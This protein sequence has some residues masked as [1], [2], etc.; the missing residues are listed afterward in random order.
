MYPIFLSI[1][2]KPCV[3]VGGGYVAY[4]K[5]HNLIDEGAVVTVVAEESVKEIVDMAEKGL[6]TLK[7]KR[8]EPSDVENAYLVF[9]A[10]NDKDVN[11]DVTTAAK[12]NKAL[13]NTVDT[14]DLCEFYSG[15]VVN[16]GPL[17]IAISTGGCSPGIAGQIRRELEELYPEPYEEFIETAGEMRKHIIDSLDSNADMKREALFW[18]ARKETRNIFFEHGKER[19]WK[20]LKN[21]ISS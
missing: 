15:A 19:L 12:K 16:R 8:F 13:I 18:L 9:A 4:H 2:G 17:K 20:E 5:I 14:P 11:A 6:L 3:I 10:T 1:T 21:F 7:T